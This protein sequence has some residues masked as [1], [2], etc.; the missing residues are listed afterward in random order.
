[1]RHLTVMGTRTGYR[2]AGVRATGG[3]AA[4]VV[5][6][7]ALTVRGLGFAADPLQV[8]TMPLNPTRAIRE[9]AAAYVE[10]T[11]QPVVVTAC[12]SFDE[13]ASGL[14]AGQFDV[15]LGTCTNSG[16]AL[17]ERA[18]VSP[19]TRRT[20]YYHRM[21]IL[22]PPG[23]PAG[24]LSAADLDRAG[25]RIG[26]FD[27]HMHGPLVDRVRPEA[28]VVSRDQR[29]LLDMVAQGDLDAALTWDCFGPVR[30]DLVTMRLPRRAA[31]EEAAMPAP[32]FVG[33]NTE[34]VIDANLFLDFCT[35]SPDARN[36]LLS[37]ALILWDGGDERYKGADHK[38]MPVYRYLAQQIVKDYAGGRADC[39]DLGCGEGQMT[40]EIA[41]LSD[42]EVTGL[43]IEPEVLE[44]ARRYAEECGV[45]ESRMHWVCA[46]VHALPYPDDSFD[47]VVSRGSMPFWRDQETAV[48]ETWRVLRPGGVAFLGGGC[49]RLCPPEV[50]EA[51]RPGGDV[52][53][54]VGEIFHFPFPMGNLHALMTRAGISDY[55]VMTEGGQ[56][57][58]FHKPEAT[59]MVA[60]RGDYR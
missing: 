9:V 2:D 20:L 25:L 10:N 46:D 45:D 47:L 21:T 1:M 24:I 14:R 51:V 15:V 43:D 59:V 50:W 27:I 42:L 5:L 40:V 22:L 56:W 6:L 31:G 11:G 34:R 39:L 13:M 28:A 26:L 4:A 44:L 38:F 58:E 48:R 37:H 18:L 53:K 57:V 36:V 19:D 8:A 52:G 55:Q 30:P 41:R 33:A 17:V 12:R 7:V 35:N 3:T 60:E 54:E 23:N 16:A 29:L 32:C 49:G